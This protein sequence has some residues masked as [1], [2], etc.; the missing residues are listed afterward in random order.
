MSN[1]NETRDQGCLDHNLDRLLE[2]GEPAPGM[3]ED[4]KVRIRSK[5]IFSRQ[6][7]SRFFGCEKIGRAHV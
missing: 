1:T 2:L 5:F 6:F 7:T 3:P 4:L